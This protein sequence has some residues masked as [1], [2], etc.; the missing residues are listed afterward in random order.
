MP[1]EGN[2]KQGANYNLVHVTSCY[3]DMPEGIE[4][5]YLVG[6]PVQLK[7]EDDWFSFFVQV[8]LNLNM[9]LTVNAPFDNWSLICVCTF[10]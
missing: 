1:R 8:Q 6:A 7:L 2:E 5:L 4:A 10:S 9:L 3:V